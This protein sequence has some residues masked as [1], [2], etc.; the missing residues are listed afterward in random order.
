[1]KRSAVLWLVACIVTLGS[2][3]WQRMSGPTYEVRVR[4]QIGGTPVRGELKRSHSITSGQPV[5]VT[6]PDAQV[7]GIVRWRRVPSEDPWQYT[8]MVRDGDRLTMT[9]PPQPMAGKVAYQVALT[10]TTPGG[11]DQ[12]ARLL[13][14]AGGE[15]VTRFKGDVPIP[16]LASHILL[17][18][19]GM[20]WSTRTGLAALA[21]D[22]GTARHVK[23]TC[24][25]LVVAGL[26]LGP[27]VQR[28]AF[29]ALWTGWPFGHD[30]TDN[31]TALAVLVWLVTLW[32]VRGGRQARGLAIAAALVTFAVFAIPH[33]TAGSE[34]NYA[35]VQQSAPPP[36]AGR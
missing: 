9:I 4:A 21:R 20:L 36:A 12:P 24:G 1:M 25:L 15:V 34:Y 28:A 5:V 6:V 11:A 18:F 2:V 19:L 7:E 22:P 26:I 17:I 3:V 31:K 8:P 10:K 30:L 29:G 35:A 16:L 13:L 23:I 27:L 32:R 33:S 14:P